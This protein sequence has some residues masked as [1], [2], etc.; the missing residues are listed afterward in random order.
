MKTR[1]N[2]LQ[3]FLALT[4]VTAAPGV[5]VAKE[6]SKSSK[7]AELRK[8]AADTLKRLYKMEPSARSVIAQAAGYAVFRN[9]GLK[10]FLAG[11][12]S[13]DGIVIDQTTKHE[14]FMKMVEIQAGLG[15]GIKK[16]SVVFVFQNPDSMT[17]FIESGWEFGA[18]ATAAVTDDGAGGGVQGAVSVDAGVWMY[19]LTDKGLALELTAKGT[20]YYRNTDLNEV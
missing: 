20:K 5:A 7:R 4:L 17:R 14:T 11:G 18:Q 15:L 1:R 8:M 12:G 10:I 2:A 3:H 6:P 9:F 13:G 19:Q 16:F